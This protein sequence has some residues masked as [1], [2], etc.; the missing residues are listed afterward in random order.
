NIDLAA[1]AGIIAAVGTG[2]NDQ[3]IITDEA[4]R[5]E[6]RRAFSWKDKIKN[7]FFVIFGAYI[8]LV[9]AMLPLLFAGAG[10]LRG[11]A[12]TTIIGV[13]VGVFITRPAYAAILEILLERD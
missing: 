2:V 1:V 7:A 5:G 10:L 13:S 12:L 8:T 3:I 4:L 9:V 11:F 6:A